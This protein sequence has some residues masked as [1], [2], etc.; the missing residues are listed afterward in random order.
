M[1][2][3]VNPH[4]GTQGPKVN[5]LY[6]PWQDVDII[7]ANCPKHTGV[8]LAR[9]EDQTFQC[10]FGHEIYKP[11]GSLTNQTTKDNYYTGEIVKV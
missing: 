10:P 9:L 11:H 1:I 6:L 8:R 3:L 7:S 5:A 4:Q 2:K